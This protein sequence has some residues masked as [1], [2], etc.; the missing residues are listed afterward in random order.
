MRG[1]RRH[2]PS[3]AVHYV[4]HQSAR[5]DLLQA[6]DQIIHIDHRADHPQKAFVVH[7]RRTDQ[8]DG[9]GGFSAAHH[10]GLPAVDAAFARGLIGAFQF[11]LQKGVGLD[12]PGGNSFGIGIQQRGIGNVVRRGNKIF[13]HGPQLGRQKFMRIKIVA[14]WIGQHHDLNRRRQI[15]QHHVQR[16]LVLGN[17]VGQRTRDRVLQQHFV[18]LEAVP[19][20]VLDLR[21]VEIHGKNADGQQH[22]KDDV[23]QRNA[24]G[25]GQLQRQRQS[26]RPKRGDALV[27]PASILSW[28][29]SVTLGA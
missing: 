8:H 13:E 1:G 15:G 25:N 6:A 14:A 9:A 11:P 22:A 17:V 2:Q 28:F 23:E 18:G 10:Q 4:G 27:R 24:R 7:D 26:C 16:F 5:T 19:V 3:L 21:R 20:H 29:A 12:A